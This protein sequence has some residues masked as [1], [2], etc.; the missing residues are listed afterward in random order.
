M[1]KINR[2]IHPELT[3]RLNQFDRLAVEIGQ[4][5]SLPLENRVWPVLK[6][7]Q[8]T[9]LTDDPHLA[10]QVRFQQHTLSKHLSKRLNLKISG[11]HIKVISLPFASFEQKIGRF[12]LSGDAALVMNNIARSI[13]D[14]EL[15]DAITRLAKTASRT[16]Q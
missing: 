10:T 7:Q 2:L 11:L 13:E 5:L 14:R 12:A 9:L 4:F 1:E 3:E 16:R 15:Q 6:N 8:L